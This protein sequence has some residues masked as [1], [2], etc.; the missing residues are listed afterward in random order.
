MRRA[1]TTTPGGKVEALPAQPA[2]GDSQPNRGFTPLGSVADGVGKR[3]VWAALCETGGSNQRM[4]QRVYISGPLT[5]SGNVLDNLA[6]AMAAARGAIRPPALPP[7][8]HT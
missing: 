5:S 3:L 6:H 4:R 1:N 2:D 8:P 7:S